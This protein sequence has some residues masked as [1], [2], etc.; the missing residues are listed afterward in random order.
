MIEKISYIARIAGTEIMKIYNGNLKLNAHQKLDKSPVTNADLLSHKIIMYAL[1][2]LTPEIPVL[3]EEDTTEWKVCR[4][5]SCFWLIDPLDGT[6]EF[7]LRNGAFTVN[8]AFI[9]YGQPIMGVVYVPAYNILYAADNG[10]VWKIN[11]RGE[12]INIAVCASHYPMIVMSRNDVDYDQH[13]LYGYLK[14]FKNYKII[15]IGSS[16]KFCLIAEGSVHFYP[17][18]SYTKIWDTAAGHVIAKSAGAIIN[19]WD[20][21]SLHYSNIN[22]SFLNPGFQVSSY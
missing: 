13:R 15:N 4:D 12:R 1:R 2:N 18:F 17:R 22:R 9:E 21:N 19:D 6:K 20:G 8:I 14:K 16:F 11:Y 3:S 5:K 7:L 10:K